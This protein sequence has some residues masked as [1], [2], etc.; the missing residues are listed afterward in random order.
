[1]KLWIS[2]KIF[3][4]GKFVESSTP[5]E[6]NHYKRP[7][8]HWEHAYKI[9]KK[10]LSEFDRIDIISTL[11]RVIDIRIKSLNQIY[12]LKRI[13]GLKKSDS[14][15]EILKTFNLIQPVMIS[16][17]I[18]VRNRI[19]HQD[20]P[21]PSTRECE[22][23]I[24]FVWYFIKSTDSH[25]IKVADGF[26]LEEDQLN[27]NDGFFLSIETGP[28]HDW[29]IKFYGTIPKE[30]TSNEKIPEW[31]MVLCDEIEFNQKYITNRKSNFDCAFIKGLVTPDSYIFTKIVHDYFDADSY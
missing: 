4:W 2:N 11:K 20:K 6:K 24:E 30:F 22:E 14:I 25:I 19:E 17:I 21:P 9:S 13:P 3:S 10:N 7:K 16:K 5:Q 1:M 23:L 12:K 8:E 31:P 29:K 28:I 26:L 27:L 18:E 15:V